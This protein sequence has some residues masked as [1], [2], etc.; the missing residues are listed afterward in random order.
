MPEISYNL[1]KDKTVGTKR[2]YGFAATIET[3]KWWMHTPRWSK[4]NKPD[5]GHELEKYQNETPTEGM[6]QDI[7]TDIVLGVERDLGLIVAA[8][9]CWASQD[10]ALCNIAIIVSDGTESGLLVDQVRA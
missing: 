2:F 4:I 7:Q 6:F 9:Y 8:V 1:E 3:V 10:D 5:F